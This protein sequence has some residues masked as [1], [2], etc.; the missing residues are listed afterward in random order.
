[1]AF[2]I[3]IF[4]SL[5]VGIC[6]GQTGQQ[7]V[8]SYFSYTISIAN[9]GNSCAKKDIIKLDRLIDDVIT[10]AEAEYPIVTGGAGE[11]YISTCGS[12]F[13][14]ESIRDRDLFRTQVEFGHRKLGIYTRRDGGWCRLC[15]SGRRI[16]KK[17][18][19]AQTYEQGNYQSTLNEWL[20][21]F[22]QWVADE[23]QKSLI[24]FSHECATVNTQIKVDI[25]MLDDVTLLPC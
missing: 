11:I 25:V 16:L 14:D 22:E 3:L 7:C 23:I 5:L 15:S 17:E 21:G 6:K 18:G 9:L 1:M 12:T 19:S 8:E 13:V 24:S 4:L 2:R 20:K 10:I